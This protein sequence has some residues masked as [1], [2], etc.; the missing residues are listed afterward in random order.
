[1]YMLA[2]VLDV[3]CPERKRDLLLHCLGAEGLRIFQTL[4]EAH[5][6]DATVKLLDGDFAKKLLKKLHFWQHAQHVG[7]SV[8]QHINDLKGLA[9]SCQFGYLRDEMIR[10]QLIERISS[11]LMWKRLL[12]E[13]DRTLVKICSHSFPSGISSSLCN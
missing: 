6:N 7:E 8:T 11:S 5:T 10:D 9:Q 1:M 4:W 3:V 12:L 2:T 13:D